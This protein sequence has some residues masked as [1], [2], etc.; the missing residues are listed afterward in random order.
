MPQEKIDT[1]R[2]LVERIAGVQP[3]DKMPLEVIG[4]K[5]DLFFNKP[6]LLPPEEL[7]LFKF[8][9]QTLF[10]LSDE[11]LNELVIQEQVILNDHILKLID[12]K[13]MRQQ[14]ER[15]RASVWKMDSMN[16]SPQRNLKPGSL[17]C[18][19][20]QMFTMNISHFKPQHY[21]LIAEYKCS[22]CHG[23]YRVRMSEAHNEQFKGEQCPLKT[24]K[25]TTC[26]KSN[27]PIPG[28]ILTM[29]AY[30]GTGS[31]EAE[32]GRRLDAYFVCFDPKITHGPQIVVGIV[33]SVQGIALPVVYILAVDTPPKVEIDGLKESNTMPEVIAALDNYVYK[34]CGIKLEGSNLLKEFFVLQAMAYHVYGRVD[35]NVL[36]VGKKDIGKNFVFK[37]YQPMLYRKSL[38][39][40]KDSVSIATLRGSF[41]V[42]YMW[43]KEQKQATDPLFSIYNNIT[44]DEVFDEPKDGKYPDTSFMDHLKAYA[45]ADNV[46]NNKQ[47]G[48]SGVYQKNAVLNAMANIMTTYHNFYKNL[49]RVTYE[50]KLSSSPQSMNTIAFDFD[51]SLDYFG[52][53]EEY[54]QISPL[55]GDAVLT[56]RQS[57]G[58]RLWQ[59][60]VEEATMKRFPFTL[61]FRMTRPLR[62]SSETTATNNSIDAVRDEVLVRRCLLND[63]W[64]EFMDLNLER[65]KNMPKDFEMAITDFF[66]EEAD[67][68][69][70]DVQSEGIDITTKQVMLAAV[71]CWACIYQ[72]TSLTD[73]LKT[74][75]KAFIGVNKTFVDEERLRRGIL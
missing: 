72:I 74:F 41:E 40:P 30:F 33:V 56:V 65:A 29:P 35:A 75:I 28:S 70:R 50:K 34:Q 10:T 67:K 69:G 59:C 17:S 7:E 2:A 18:R 52:P 15:S 25:G 23:T 26:G 60:G 24:S 46:S 16:P 14:L 8:L 71:K 32:E 12:F 73:E 20:A 55:L 37:Y 38:F 22:K 27:D 54:S 62:F 48:R 63:T 64:E 68:R 39:T 21:P 53:I 44:I 61:F 66:F 13:T 42:V 45:L 19:T 57:L 51:R 47:G 6:E 58:E 43:G 36:L 1:T 11:A 49:I 3:F 5:V 4:R 9:Q 31:F